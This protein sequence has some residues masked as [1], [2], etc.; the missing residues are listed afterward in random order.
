M[1]TSTFNI[2]I[3]EDNLSH[4]TLTKYA[5]ES[6]RVPAACHAVQDGQE[7]LDY[8]HRQHKFADDSRY[9][10]PDLILLDLNLPKRDGREVLHIIRSDEKLSRIPV[11]VVSTSD[12]PEDMTFALEK[13]AVAYI[14]KS[15]G[16]ENFNR[17]FSDIEKYLFKVWGSR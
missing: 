16:F 3:I 5:L 14:S 15:V 8:L 7:A 6:N 9:P 11:V 4:L 17:S 12:R 2:L 13:G 1:P 10:M